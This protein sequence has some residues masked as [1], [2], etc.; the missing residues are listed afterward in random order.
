MSMQHERIAALCA[1]LKLDHLPQ[2]VS[3]ST[4]KPWLLAEAAVRSDRSRALLTRMAG[5]PAIKRLE[6]YDF[7][8]AVGAPKVLIQEL[9]SL[10]FIERGENVMLIG[11][12]RGGQNPFGH[13]AGVQGHSERG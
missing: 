6:Q 10:A 8:F 9:A 13:C 7:Q 2:R 3:P 5:F 4:W 12:S 1:E 11:P